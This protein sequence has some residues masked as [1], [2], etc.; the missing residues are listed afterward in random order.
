MRQHMV[1]KHVMEAGASVDVT[2]MAYHYQQLA[3]IVG[4]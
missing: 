4:C 1:K 2:H 3:V